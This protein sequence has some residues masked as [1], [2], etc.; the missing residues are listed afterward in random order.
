MNKVYTFSDDGQQNLF[1]FIIVV[2]YEEFV[3]TFLWFFTFLNFYTCLP[4]VLKG[5][6]RS[7]VT[8]SL[9]SLRENS[10]G[11]P[12]NPLEVEV[13]SELTSGSLLCPKVTT[14]PLRQP[15]PCILS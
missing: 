13:G 3:L 15:F 6:G 10:G 9:G 5:R 2:R 14:F 12:G 1:F 8:L 7:E 4:L 11:T